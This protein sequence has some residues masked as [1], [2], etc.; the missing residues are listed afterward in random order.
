MQYFELPLRPSP[1]QRPRLTKNGM[2]YTPRP[3]KVAEH[4]IRNM[5]RKLNPQKIEG[6]ISITV[7]FIYKKP[8][9]STNRFHVVRPDIDNLLKLLLDGMQ[10]KYGIFEDDKNVVQI[11]ATKK[12]GEKDMIKLWVKEIEDKP[13]I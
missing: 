10:D 5:L 4:M 13:P 6:A 12:Y 8:K 9:T 11:A 7:E 2:A 3:T 1:K